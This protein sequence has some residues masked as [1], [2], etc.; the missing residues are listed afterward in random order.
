VVMERFDAFECLRLIEQHGVDKVS[1]VPTM[2]LRI[3]RLADSE[4][5]ARNVSSLRAVISV[6]APCPPWLMRSWI[7]WLG[8]EIMNETFGSSERIGGTYINGVEWLQHP[9]SVG[10]PVGGAQ[11]KIVDPQTGA[12]CET[13]AMGEIYMIPRAGPGSSFRYLGA[14]RR[15]LEGGWESVGDMGYVDEAG[16]LYLGDRRNDMI[17]SGGRNIYPAEV[18]AVLEEYQA[19]R[20]AA[21]IGLPDDDVGQRIHAI[22]EVAEAVDEEVLKHFVGERLVYYKVPRTIEFVDYPLRN[23]AGKVRRSALRDARLAATN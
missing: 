7:E 17:V 19:V 14:D 1:L 11:L 20:S 2:M 10:K 13:G 4:R 15:T 12:E 22:A 18:E 23:D 8:P 5:L 9:G 3:T 21:V 16:Y 6:G